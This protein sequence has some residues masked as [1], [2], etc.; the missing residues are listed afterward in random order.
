MKMNEIR[1]HALA[2]KLSTSGLK[3]KKKN[4]PQESN[5]SFQWINSYTVKVICWQLVDGII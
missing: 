5:L 4:T 3:K 1:M 2:S